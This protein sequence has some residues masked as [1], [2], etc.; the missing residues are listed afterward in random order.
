MQCRRPRFNSWVRKIP[1]RRDRLPTPA[2]LGFPGG[3][4]CICLQCRR[5]G[6]YPWFGKIHWR[7]EWL[8]TP[9]FS[10]GEIHELYIIS[11]WGCSVG[12]DWT[13]FTFHFHIM[14]ILYYIHFI[15]IRRL[16]ITD[17]TSLGNM[18][19]FI[20]SHIISLETVQFLISHKDVINKDTRWFTGTSMYFLGKD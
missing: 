19:D 3:S 15:I 1:W 13:T 5:P 16:I 12:N 18:D 4:A 20:N 14:L 8:P 6:F 17:L 10:P 11:P 7:R 9:V 2:F